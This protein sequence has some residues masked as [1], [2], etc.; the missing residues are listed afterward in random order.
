MIATAAVRMGVLFWFGGYAAINP[1]G[2]L[3]IFTF[4]VVPIFWAFAAIRFAMLRMHSA[5]T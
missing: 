3:Q 5:E 1:E 2:M 4:L